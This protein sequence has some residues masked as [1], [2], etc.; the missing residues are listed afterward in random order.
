[1]DKSKVAKNSTDEIFQSYH[2][3]LT[4][5]DENNLCFIRSDGK[6][7]CELDKDTDSLFNIGRSAFDLLAGAK[8]KSKEDF[9]CAFC[10]YVQSLKCLRSDFKK[11]F[12]LHLETVKSKHKEE[13]ITDWDKLSDGL[14]VAIYSETFSLIQSEMKPEATTA[15]RDACLMN[16]LLEINNALTGLEFEASSAVNAAIAAC[17]SLRNALAIDSGDLKHQRLKRAIALRG[18]KAKHIKTNEIRK[19]VICH[20]REHIPPETSNEKAGEWLKDTF[21]ELS[22]RKLSEYVAQAKKGRK[23]V[24]PASKA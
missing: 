17:E 5:S 9:D 21:P 18:A 16:T 19:L 20:W 12:T 3:F 6:S 10:E 4:Y 8:K 22:V 13:A 15:V 11:K 2:P 14:L 24:P 7:F 23:E 1:M